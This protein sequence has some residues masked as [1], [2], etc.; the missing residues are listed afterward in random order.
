MASLELTLSVDISK[1]DVALNFIKSH[2]DTEKVAEF[3]S[4]VYPEDLFETELK[5]GP[6]G[7]KVLHFV[8]SKKLEEFLQSLGKAA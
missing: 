1:L 8:P 4:A 7:T 3:G 5:N 2:E 6:D